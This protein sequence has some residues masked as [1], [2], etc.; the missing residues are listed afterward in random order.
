[1]LNIPVIVNHDQQG[2]VPLVRGQVVDIQ[3]DLGAYY[4]VKCRGTDELT[5]IQK[6]YIRHVTSA[7]LAKLWR[8]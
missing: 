7:E 8:M 6:G 1:M 2:R 5:R 4:L 3:L